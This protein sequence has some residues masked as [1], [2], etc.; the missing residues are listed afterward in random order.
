MVAL[1]VV[2]VV[3]LMAM[4]AAQAVRY[5]MMRRNREFEDRYRR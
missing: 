2:V 4:T 1:F 3:F 5:R